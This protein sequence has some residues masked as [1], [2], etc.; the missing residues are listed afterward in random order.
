MTL[1]EAQED[2]TIA[3]AHLVI[4]AYSKGW[5][6]RSKELLRTPYQAKEYARL[7]KG[8][9]NSVHRK[10]L[11]IDIALSIN[12]AVTWDVE[13]YRVLGTKWKKLHPLSRWGGDFPGRDAV[14]FSFEWKGVR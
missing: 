3:W 13:K 8:I 2:W 14:H 4:F 10:G 5:S 6:I 11:A 9:L 7:G 12:G 1:G